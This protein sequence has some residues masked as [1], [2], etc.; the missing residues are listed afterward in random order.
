MDEYSNQQFFLDLNTRIRNLEDRQQLMNERVLLTGKTLVEER[1][2]NFEDIQ[3]LKKSV[4]QLK[5]ESKKMG[6][7]L[8]RMTE[9]I[10]SLARKEEIL[11]LK[12]QFD[13]FREK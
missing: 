11:M 8:K 10:D 1:E 7:V 12:R 4:L 9:Q 3:S 6:E 5:E 13:L 2:K